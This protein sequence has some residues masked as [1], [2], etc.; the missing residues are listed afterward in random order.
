MEPDEPKRRLE[1]PWT[2]KRASETS[3]T[4][5]TANGIVVAYVYC[6]DAAHKVTSGWNKLSSDEARRIATAIARLPE[7]LEK[8]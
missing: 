7:L 4:V 2:P 1:A 5:T 6:D 3:Y 8:K